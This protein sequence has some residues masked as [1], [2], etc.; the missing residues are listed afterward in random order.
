LPCG[1]VEPVGRDGLRRVVP[2][3]VDAAAMVN[4][5]LVQALM[6]AVPDHGALLI[7]GDIDQLYLR[8][9]DNGPNRLALEPIRLNYRRFFRVFSFADAVI[10]PI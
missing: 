1:V 9:C 4:V 6:R 8:E 10:D 5:T 2:T 7:V 3:F